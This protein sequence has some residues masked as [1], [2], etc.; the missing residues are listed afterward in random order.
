[1]DDSLLISHA[2]VVWKYL[3]HAGESYKTYGLSGV[4]THPCFRERG[5][6]RQIVETGTAYIKCSDADIAMLW[7]APSLKGFYA[8]SGWIGLEKSRTLIGPKQAPIVYHLLLM[9]LFISEKGKDSQP[10]FE[11]EPIYFGLEA[12]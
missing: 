12:W 9:M 3:E 7:C 10:A 1:V 6:A 2:A 11:S 8:R 5:Y 4:F